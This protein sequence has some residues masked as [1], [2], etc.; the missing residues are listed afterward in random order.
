MAC[1]TIHTSM[2]L[3]IIK[4]SLSLSLIFIIYPLTCLE[5]ISSS[6]V[7]DGPSVLF[8][9]DFHQLVYYDVTT[10]TFVDDAAILLA[11]SKLLVYVGLF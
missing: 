1:T 3:S 9:T 7:A 5:E 6:Y 10:A 8:T 2:I 11:K 4:L